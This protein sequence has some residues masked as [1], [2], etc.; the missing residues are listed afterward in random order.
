MS[1]EMEDFA[2]DVTEFTEDIL[3]GAM[4][5]VIR[6]YEGRGHMPEYAI[7]YAMKRLQAALPRAC[8]QAGITDSAYQEFAMFEI[9]HP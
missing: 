7:Y 9:K 3:A 2:T 5:A 8:S 4:A 6:H 1:G